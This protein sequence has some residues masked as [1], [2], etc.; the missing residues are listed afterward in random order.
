MKSLP[1]KFGH[2]RNFY[3][4]HF[5]VSV[6]DFEVVAHHKASDVRSDP[7][8]GHVV[9]PV[10]HVVDIPLEGKDNDSLNVG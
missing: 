2:P 9:E 6:T 3:L 5:D 4:G 10:Q 8:V 1:I 7:T